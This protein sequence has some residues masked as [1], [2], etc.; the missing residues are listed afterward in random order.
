MPINDGLN[1]ADPILHAPVW[2]MGRLMN[3]AAVRASQELQTK[4]G[5]PQGYAFGIETPCNTKYGV[6]Q[7]E[8]NNEI[9]S[10]FLGI[11]LAEYTAGILAKKV[12]EGHCNHHRKPPNYEP[13]VD[14]A[15][16]HLEMLKAFRERI[17]KLLAEVDTLIGQTTI[18]TPAQQNKTGL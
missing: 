18:P 1:A 5:L 17:A 13:C 8:V 10:W 9:L 6:T 15:N 4:A 14:M 12:T 16:E 2:D 7:T 11:L 3:E